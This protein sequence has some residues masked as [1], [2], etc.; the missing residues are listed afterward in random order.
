MGTGLYI[1]SVVKR[2]WANC[3][4][5]ILFFLTLIILLAKY[6]T[7]WVSPALLPGWDTSGHYY[8][9]LKQLELLHSGHLH[10]YIL[11]W[12]GG[13]P[14]FYFYS[15]LF[16][17]VTGLASITLPFLPPSLIFKLV[18]LLSL[19]ALTPSFYYF[20]Q[21]F[22]PSKPNPFIAIALS[23]LFI[24][25]QPYEFGNLGIG[26]P[27][28]IASGLINQGP[29]LIL[30][31]LFLAL[32][33]KLLDSPLYFWE[34]KYFYFSIISGSALIYTHIL[35]AVFAVLFS[36]LLFLFYIKN[37]V[38]LV[39]ALIVC[40]GILLVSAYFVLPF[41]YSYDYS[42]GWGYRRTENFFAD[43]LQPLLAFDLLDLYYGRLSAFN[44]PWL[45]VMI[46]SVVGFIALIKRQ[47]LVLPVLF[48]IPFL[49]IPRN[50][51]PQMLSR[52]SLQYYRIIPMLII[53]CLVASLYGF[54]LLWDVMKKNKKYLIPNLVFWSLL[55]LLVVWRVAAFSFNPDQYN[56]KP[57][58]LK[59]TA[60]PTQY[61]Q[62]FSRYP[63]QAA[64]N[65]LIDC[66]KRLPTGE[67]RI[68]VDNDLHLMMQQIGSAH[69]FNFILP[70]M[71]YP[72]VQGLYSE[73]AN[74]T[75]FI[76]PPLG[77]LSPT[78]GENTYPVSHYL[79]W[80]D[81]YRH[82]PFSDSIRQ[83]GLFNTQYIIAYHSDTKDNIDNIK[84][85]LVEPV[86]CPDTNFRLYNINTAV[87]RPYV[88]YPKLKPILY[89]QNDNNDS[90]S[91]RKISLGWYTL[92]GLFDAP[93]IYKNGL[94]VKSLDE[95][96]AG[97]LVNISAIIVGSNGLNNG[98]I[99]ILKISGKPVLV[100]ADKEYNQPDKLPDYF[101][102]IS[103]FKPIADFDEY[104]QPY[105]P[106]GDTLS[107]LQDFIDRKVRLATNKAGE[108]QGIN[109]VTWRDSVINFTAWGPTI[110]NA[111]YFPSW[112][113]R[114]KGQEIYEVTPGQMLV[115]A[116]G[117]SQL[118]FRAT[119]IDL[120]G[121]TISVLSCLI[122][123][124]I[125]LKKKRHGQA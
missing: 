49:L 23:L 99:D 4:Y 65:S 60:N 74:Q 112:R 113:S 101:E 25:F 70:V 88:S 111:S 116:N 52:I 81:I 61:Y 77:V 97:D 40:F 109:V 57:N 92:S 34:D 120:V 2:M 13:M 105:F 84:Q 95:I 103:N 82:Q 42:S 72:V 68:A 43:P 27:G 80:N 12:F 106:N 47:S 73:S 17:W 5:L 100:L 24:F 20:S 10:G 3:P 119:G 39:K 102:V 46:G 36:F 76:Y 66:I 79:M 48:L 107:K 63:G 31:F 87:R 83:L 9:F 59:S 30:G 96:P 125:G 58:L 56:F 117:N 93:I 91:F 118:E 124:F 41:L 110:V 94:R 22:L 71:G 8:A 108:A 121:G 122:L 28:A 51:L 114:L 89:V 64:V 123:L 78:M 19:S 69:Y 55:I 18:I 62:N 6:P 85:D 35:S 14:L 98:D 45:T 33:K 115:F 38:S 75:A 104:N 44:W 54:S 37:K 67:G 7:L 26:L 16:F 1:K 53:L 86:Y 32:F 15:P 11:D 90:L 29:G 50:Y 21:I